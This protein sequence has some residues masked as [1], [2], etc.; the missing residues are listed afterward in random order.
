MA[1]QD[2]T[3]RR[4]WF[5]ANYC[6]LKV[7]KQITG[8]AMQLIE[9]RNPRWKTNRKRKGRHFDTH[10]AITRV[11]SVGKQKFGLDSV[12][13]PSLSIFGVNSDPKTT[14]IVFRLGFQSQSSRRSSYFCDRHYLDRYT[15][16][17][18]P[19]VVFFSLLFAFWSSVSRNLC[20]FSN[21]LM[22]KNKK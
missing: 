12:L 15:S 1:K 14:P 10:N 2:L 20:V 8:I 22:T 17:Y 18:P 3:V 13:F 19:L 16:S 9:N 21:L 7:L 11:Q 6:G 4:Q 5:S